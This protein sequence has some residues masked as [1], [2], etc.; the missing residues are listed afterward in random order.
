[1]RKLLS[2]FSVALVAIFAI[3]CDDTTEQGGNKEVTFAFG[4]PEATSTSI[5]IMVMPSDDKIN[6][7]AGIV[8][9]SEIAT[10]DDATIITEYLQSFSMRTGTQLIGAQGLTPDTDYMVIAFAYGAT[11]KVSKVAAR[12]AEAGAVSDGFYVDIAVNDITSNSAIAVPSWFC[13]PMVWH[14]FFG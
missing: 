9:A 1:M 3:G 12:T 4:Q 6:Y 10:K 2:I 14:Q 11:D 7:F 13:H 8:P 5:E